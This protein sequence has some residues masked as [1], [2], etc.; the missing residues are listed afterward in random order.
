M[1][2]SGTPKSRHCWGCPDLRDVLS[3]ETSWFQRHPDLRDILIWET[4]WFERC[5][6]FR[7]ALIWETSWFER[8][9]DF[10]GYFYCMG[11]NTWFQGIGF[12]CITMW[13]LSFHL[14]CSDVRIRIFLC[15][16]ILD[17]FGHLS[18]S[19]KS[20]L[21]AYPVRRAGSMLSVEETKVVRCVSERLV[22]SQA[23]PQDGSL[24]ATSRQKSCDGGVRSLFVLFVC[25]FVCLFFCLHQLYTVEPLY[26]FRISVTTSA[27]RIQNYYTITSATRKLILTVSQYIHP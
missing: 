16:V 1:R 17:N 5:P 19:D 26:K 23:P 10:R 6:D 20:I 12:C 9:P 14:L 25:L 3:W 11:Q 15:R 7:D 13:L 22:S 8:R 2:I 27:I 24:P 4:S 21:M 18:A